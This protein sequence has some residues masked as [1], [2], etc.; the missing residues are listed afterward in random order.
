[1]SSVSPSKE[2]LPNTPDPSAPF[3]AEAVIVNQGI[4]R[5]TEELRQKVALQERKIAEQTAIINQQKKDAASSRLYPGK[6]KQEDDMG[7]RLKFLRQHACALAWTPLRIVPTIL[8]GWAA[9]WVFIWCYLWN[10]CTTMM[11]WFALQSLHIFSCCNSPFVEYAQQMSM[12]YAG[13]QNCFWWR[14][15][16]ELEGLDN[17]NMYYVV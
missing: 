6:Y 7:L 2:T 5:E 14:A 1:M 15:K 16:Y 4:E 11:M 12:R 10:L 17:D 3:V 8:L 13:Q 9:M